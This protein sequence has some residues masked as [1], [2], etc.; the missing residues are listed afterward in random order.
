MSSIGASDDFTIMRLRVKNTDLDPLAIRPRVENLIRDIRLYP[1]LPESASL[2]IRK[3]DDPSP[4]LLQLEAIDSRATQ[5]WRRSFQ[6]RFEQ[7]VTS[8]ARPARGPVSS[9]VESVVFIDYSELLACLTAD[10]CNGFVGARWWWR[11]FLQRGD[12]EQVVKR[13]WRE[14]IEYAPAA[15]Q[16]LAAKSHVLVEFVEGLSDVE[17]CELIERVVEK[18]ALPAV[19]RRVV[20]SFQREVV[21]DLTAEKIPVAAQR[22]K[23]P[24][25]RKV[26]PPWR[27]VV[28]E[29]D[30]PRLRPV[31]QMFLGVALMIRRAPA[32]VRTERFAREVERWQEAILVSFQEVENVE[33]VI[34]EEVIRPAIEVVAEES[35]ATDETDQERIEGVIVE[36]ARREVAPLVPEGVEEVVAVEVEP[37]LVVESV[38][39]MVGELAVV[40]VAET[41]DIATPEVF[42]ELEE[43]FT[44]E[45]ELGGIF[46]LINLAIFLEIYSDFT[47][48]VENFTE[49]NIW[50]FVAFVGSEL[51]EHQ[52]D[53]DP[54][55]LLLASLAGHEEFLRGE[56]QLWLSRLIP[57]IR[58]R[59]HR[60]LGVDD[61]PKILLHHHARITITATHIDVFFSLSHLPIEIRLSGLDR[62]PGWVPAAARFIAFHFE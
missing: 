55:W 27:Y 26:V 14:K 60:A 19:M 42:V 13:Y 15:L 40:E 2:F 48:P 37:Q 50:D 57:D 6:T 53:D 5:T 23:E 62:D 45:T 44:V 8:A 47:S 12:I 31:Q 54:I 51:N 24:E 39:E 11:S 20:G 38:P 25:I 16:Q 59:L 49:L 22:V 61:L 32:E 33:E 46:Y 41:I 21:V 36:V 9:S 3:L 29:S 17:C 52:D 58:T 30:T 56:T 43:S 7:L 35:V 34:E 18:F 1:L 28:P 4:G 10:W